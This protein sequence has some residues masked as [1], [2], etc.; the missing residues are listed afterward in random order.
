MS[1][2]RNSYRHLKRSY[3]RNWSV[4]SSSDNNNNHD[5]S[6][7]TTSIEDIIV[8]S[9][10]EFV[11]EPAAEYPYECIGVG[12]TEEERYIIVV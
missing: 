5:I 4:S 10:E 11:S 7:S 8:I 3:Y 12:F 2:H 6:S 1:K 9:D